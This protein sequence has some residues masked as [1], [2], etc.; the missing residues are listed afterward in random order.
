MA[1]D[2][3]PRKRFARH[4]V[5]RNR[6]TDTL[7]VVC[8]SMRRSHSECETWLRIPDQAPI[9]FAAN[10]LGRSDAA[11][12]VAEGQVF[13]SYMLLDPEGR[14]LYNDNLE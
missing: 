1:I 13:P 3:S 6:A 5:G 7:D 14:I 4:F 2:D 8:A 11:R 10:H 12:V 9:G